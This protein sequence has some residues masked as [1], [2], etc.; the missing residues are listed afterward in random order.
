MKFMTADVEI[1]VDDSKLSTQLAKA[2]SA[3]TK[4]VDKIKTSFKKMGASFKAVFSKMVHYAKWGGVAIAGAFLLVTRAAMKQ[5]D[6]VFL[7]MSAL[8]ISGEY[9][10]AL[11]Q[12]FRA[13]ASSIQET[14]VYGDEEVLALMQLQKSLGVTADKLEIAAKQS[15]G[16]ATATGRDVKSMAMY[17]ALAQQGEFT[18]LRRYIPALRQTTDKTEQLKIITEF[19]AA[20]FKLAEERAKTAS[21]GL[22]QMWNALGDVAEVIG[23]AFLPGIYDTATAIK[24]WAQRNQERIGR[25]AETAVAYVTYIKDI[26]WAFVK[27]LGTDWKEGI[28]VGLGVSLEIFKGFGKSLVVIMIDVASRAWRAFVK[29]FSE[30]LGRWLIE[31]SKP[32][33]VLGKILAVTPIGVAKRLGMMKAGVGLVEGSR[34]VKAPEGP[35]LGER[36]KGVWGEVGISIKDI[37]PPELQAQLEEPLNRLR[38]RLGEIG[39]VTEELKD[40]MEDALIKPA[41]EASEAFSK[42]QEKL[43]QW[44]SSAKNIWDKI[45]GVATGALDSMADSLTTFVMTGK[46]NFNALANSILADLTRIII[47]QQMAQVLGAFVPGLFGAGAA[48]AVP[49]LQQGGEVKK[50]GLAV[51]HKGETFSGVDKP[52]GKEAV[53]NINVNAIDAQGTYQFLSRNKRAIATLLQ[54]AMVSNHPLRRTKGWK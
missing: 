33:G 20:G 53:V 1:K 19:A 16:L 5:Q 44:A 14:T 52:E 2:R 37:I 50:T 21:G 46:A 47:K 13:F 29:E 17:I 8:K 43:S 28:K 24:E 10:K 42:M 31:A 54:G 22:R 11:E 41:K 27:F 39:A 51:V 38:E 34:A 49:G 40:P 45:A 26:L 23:A 3:V 48:V 32:K 6:A 4:T 35:T 7:L 25:F 36:L 15:I 30:G 18:M 9:T 12:R